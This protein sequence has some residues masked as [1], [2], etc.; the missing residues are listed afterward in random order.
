MSLLPPSK[1][2]S[3]APRATLMSPIAS[4]ATPKPREARFTVAR[5]ILALNSTSFPFPIRFTAFWQSDRRS[6]KSRVNE[7]YECHKFD[8]GAGVLADWFKVV[9]KARA[10][11]ESNPISTC[12]HC[13]FD[14]ICFSSDGWMAPGSFWGWSWHEKLWTGASK[15]SVK[16]F[17]HMKLFLCTCRRCLQL[18]TKN[19]V[20]NVTWQASSLNNSKVK[21]I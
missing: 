10:K 13:R 5:L 18:V 9:I 14:L 8:S 7:N 3:I 21:A 11:I 2:A 15:V 19:S 4:S 6:S 16:L 20:Q 1:S 17:F 12:R